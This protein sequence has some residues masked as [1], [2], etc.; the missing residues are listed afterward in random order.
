ML[1]LGRPHYA[2]I[3]M[4]RMKKFRKYLAGLACIVACAGFPSVH[5]QTV[6]EY[7]HTDALGTPIAVTDANRNVIERSEYEP[8][9]Q[10][11]NRTLADGPGFTGHVQDAA[12]GLTYMQQRYY[13]PL[14]ARFLSVDP[15]T[16]YASPV[17]NFNRYLYAAN[18]PYR[19]L[20]P[21][22]RKQKDNN[23]PCETA[24]CRQARQEERRRRREEPY[25]PTTGRSYDDLPK[26]QVNFR[27]YAEPG[28]VAEIVDGALKRSS[29]INTVSGGAGELVSDRYIYTKRY[30]WIDLT[31]LVSAL[32]YPGSLIGKSLGD[33]REV[34]QWVTGSSSALRSED[35][36]A[37]RIAAQANMG[38]GN[39]YL[40]GKTKGQIVQMLINEAG[41]MTREQAQE[42]LGR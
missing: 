9:G 37:H 36:M 13:D 42:F 21:D 26:D 22:G 24:E 15:V 11:L 20:D 5:A 3:G 34:K 4:T 41:S 39:R 32:A 33:S 16:A 28:K 29:I 8:F 30:G 27:S 31:H 7:I 38:Y 10:L 18:N 19:F 25:A 1:G 35:L 23:E 2:L 40:E 6:V 14:V 17:P 12:T